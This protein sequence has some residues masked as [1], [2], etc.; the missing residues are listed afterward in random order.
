MSMCVL[1]G[2]HL[3]QSSNHVITSFVFLSVRLISRFP[4]L[5]VNSSGQLK[6]RRQ[7]SELFLDGVLSPPCQRMGAMVAFQCFDDFKR[8]VSSWCDFFVVILAIMIGSFVTWQCVFYFFL[9]EFWRGPLQLCRTSPGGFFNGRVL[10]W[11]LWGGVRQG[12]CCRYLKMLSSLFV[13]LQLNN[14]VFVPSE[15][16]G[17]PNPHHQRVH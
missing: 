11:F 2:V 10:F 15:H 14:I 3:Q 16:K 13:P 1:C 5:P 17:Q 6:M 9:Q 7:S 12:E 8:S 4:S